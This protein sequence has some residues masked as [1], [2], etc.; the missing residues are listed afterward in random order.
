MV[1]CQRFSSELLL[2]ARDMKISVYHTAQG[3]LPPTCI[4]VGWC[5]YIHTPDLSTCIRIYHHMLES[6]RSSVLETCRRALLDGGAV[7]S[8]SSSRRRREGGN[9]KKIS[10]LNRGGRRGNGIDDDDGDKDY[11]FFPLE[12][13]DESSDDDDDSC[14]LATGEASTDRECDR[15]ATAAPPGDG[16]MHSN[17]CFLCDYSTNPEVKFVSGFIADNVANM[18]IVLMAE[19]ISEYVCTQRPELLQQED[20]Q[21]CAVG[22]DDDE[23][24]VHEKKRRKKLLGI[25]PETVCRHIRLHMLSPSVRIADLMRHLLKLCDNLRKN[26]EKVDPDTGESVVDRANVDTYLKVVTKV[27]DMYK[28]SETSKMLFATNHETKG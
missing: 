28:M 18:D 19:Q 27:L 25:D 14:D 20:G 2:L 21:D 13:E 15:P 23:N 7:D 17:R 26:L 16:N 11:C 10:S 24:R 22:G 8:S 1:S 12:E 6:P 9:K 5:V 3:R 4:H